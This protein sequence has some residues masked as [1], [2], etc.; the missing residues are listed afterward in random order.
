MGPAKFRFHRGEY[1]PVPESKREAFLAKWG[2]VQVPFLV[3]PNTDT[4]LF[5]SAKIVDYLNQQYAK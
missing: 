2:N 5:E 4:N 3:D 1:R